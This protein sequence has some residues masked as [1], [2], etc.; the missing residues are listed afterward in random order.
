MLQR[1][2][3]AALSAAGIVS[4][5]PLFGEYA[6][7]VL[8]ALFGALVALS[9]EW[10]TPRISAALFVFRAVSISTALSSVAA[11]YVAEKLGKPANEL[12]IPVAFSL[13]MIGDGWFKVRDWMLTKVKK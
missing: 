4:A 9:K 1:H 6:I 13:A 10:K 3:Q 11:A 2:D 12:L 8:A 5:S 7:I